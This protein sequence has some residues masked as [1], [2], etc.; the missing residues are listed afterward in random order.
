VCN[1]WRGSPTPAADGS[2]AAAAANSAS[3]ARTPSFGST[4][5]RA[6]VAP[7]EDEDG[8]T[9]QMEVRVVSM[10]QDAHEIAYCDGP[11]VCCMCGYNKAQAGCRT[12]GVRFCAGTHSCLPFECMNK[13]LSGCPVKHAV[14]KQVG[15]WVPEGS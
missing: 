15:W 14:R 11:G 7:E 9:P 10:Q 5:A 3:T 6:R 4:R 1:L 12:C 2:A 13:H 8:E